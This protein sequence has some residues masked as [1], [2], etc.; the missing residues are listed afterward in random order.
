MSVS[1]MKPYSLIII[2]RLWS[3]S[4]KKSYRIISSISWNPKKKTLWLWYVIANTSPTE[5]Q[6]HFGWWWVLYWWDA[7]QEDIIPSYSWVSILDARTDKP[8]LDCWQYWDPKS[9]WNRYLPSWKSCYAFIN[10]YTFLSWWTYQ[11]IWSP[12]FWSWTNPAPSIAWEFIQ[13]IVK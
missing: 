1:S 13:I 2:C 3:R 7:V 5:Q 6:I 8:M 9:D 11:F 10:S 12:A 4:Q